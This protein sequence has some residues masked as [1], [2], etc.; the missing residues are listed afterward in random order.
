V[1]DK[2]EQ[3]L[4]PFR[5]DDIPQV[6]EFTPAR[7]RATDSCKAS[8]LEDDKHVLPTGKG[9]EMHR[10]IEA[11]RHFFEHNICP[12]MLLDTCAAVR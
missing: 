9:S 10:A 3:T 2:R 5:P 11:A 1:K 12:S 7:P 8:L 4:L 6:E